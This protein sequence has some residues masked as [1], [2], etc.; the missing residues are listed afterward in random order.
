MK[1]HGRQS[2]I[3]EII[4]GKT[5]RADILPKTKVE[6]AVEDKDVK[7]VTDII[8]KTACT[9]TIGDGKIFVSTVDEVIRIRTGEKDSDAI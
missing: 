9:G 1:G 7:E 5:I 3:V 8:I 2:G 4:S 6:I